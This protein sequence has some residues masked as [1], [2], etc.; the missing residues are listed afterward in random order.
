M[1]PF[2]SFKSPT[3]NFDVR[4]QEAYSRHNILNRE[5]INKMIGPEGV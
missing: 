2:S 1:G 3:S 4:N 5:Y